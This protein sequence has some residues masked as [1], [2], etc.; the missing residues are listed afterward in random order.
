MDVYFLKKWIQF[1][2]AMSG[3]SIIRKKLLTIEGQRTDDDVLI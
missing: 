2:L 3:T 1:G